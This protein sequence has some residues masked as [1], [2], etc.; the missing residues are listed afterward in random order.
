[1]PQLNKLILTAAEYKVLIIIPNG[2]AFPLLTAESLSYS[3]VRESEAF[4]AIGEEKPIGVKR[5]A[6]RYTGKLTMQNGELSDI[7][8]ICGLVEAPQIANATLAITAIQ[9]AFSRTYIGININT[10]NLDVKAKDK[11]SI[12]SLDWE[13]L[14]LK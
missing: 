12:V 8:Q 4:Y 3:N 11:Q 10:E 1:M 9:G 13:A 5:N 2:G 14:D 6:A 7:L